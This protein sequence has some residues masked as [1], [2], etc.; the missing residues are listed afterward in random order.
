MLFLYVKFG[1]PLAFLYA[2]S[3]GWGRK[4]VIP[5]TPLIMKFH[6]SPFYNIMFKGFA[7][8]AIIMILYLFFRKFRLSYSV[9]GIS[10][11]AILLSTSALDSLPRY[12]SVIFPIYI[13]MALITRKNRF[14]GYLFTFV[15][16]LLLILF[17]IMFVNGYWF[18]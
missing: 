9:Y 6:Y 16:I 2:V 4:L 7:I 8:F 12:I 17:T 13:A 3:T 1:N 5:F 15:S 14:L 11:L 10:I 18:T